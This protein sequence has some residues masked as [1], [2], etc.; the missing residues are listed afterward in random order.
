M[1]K[2]PRIVVNNLKCKMGALRACLAECGVTSPYW[3][4]HIPPLA[5]FLS[6][7]S[8]LHLHLQGSKGWFVDV[9]LYIP[10]KL[11]Y[12]DVANYF[13]TPTRT[14]SSYFFIFCEWFMSLS[15]LRCLKVS[16]FLTKVFLSWF[17]GEFQCSWF[18]SGF[19]GFEII[20]HATGRPEQCLYSW[21]WVILC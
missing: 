2:I 1:R 10:R 17:W 13:C 9:S 15:E 3:I 8:L 4:P 7:C 12:P 18:E 5:L 14:F 20:Y 21:P 11:H 16:S 6:L 19:S